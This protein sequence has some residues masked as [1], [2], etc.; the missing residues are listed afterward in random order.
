MSCKSAVIKGYG[1]HPHK[2]NLIDLVWPFASVGEG[3][4]HAVEC[5]FKERADELFVFAAG[6]LHV[7][8][9]R[10]AVALGQMLLAQAGIG[11][12]AE[13]FFRFFDGMQQPTHSAAV[14]PYVDSSRVNKAVMHEIYEELVKVIATQM[15]VPVACQYLGD[16]TVHLH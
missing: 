2:E 7:E 1:W 8:M 11:L 9:H 6:H 3:A 16:I 10:H 5:P 12:E 15:I 14:G 4:M 13:P